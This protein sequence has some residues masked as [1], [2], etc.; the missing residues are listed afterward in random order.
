MPHIAVKI[1]VT[2]I[3]ESKLF[4]GAKGTYLDAILIDTPASKFGDY[5]VVQGVSKE[6]REAGIRG[7]ILGNA[8]FVGR[9]PDANGAI[10]AP[11]KPAAPAAAPAKSFNDEDV[12]F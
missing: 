6:E 3:D 7:A 8:K 2:K 11:R 5:M 4:K 1:D 9:K 10:A 12:P